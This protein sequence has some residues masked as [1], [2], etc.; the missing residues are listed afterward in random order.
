MKLPKFDFFNEASWFL[1]LL[2]EYIRVLEK[3]EEEQRK[4]PLTLFP[5]IFF[6]EASY[7]TS[8]SGVMP[9]TLFPARTDF[10]CM[11]FFRRP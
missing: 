10:L 11:P 2:Q 9:L 3:E 8:F 4:L 6:N 7:L 5:V 1:L